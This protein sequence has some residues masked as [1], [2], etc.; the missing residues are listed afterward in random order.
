METRVIKDYFG[1]YAKKVPISAIKSMTGECL[2][3]SGAMQSV[4]SIMAINNGVIPPTINYQEVDDE[5]DLDYVPNKSRKLEVR[6]AL[7]DDFSD[8]GNISSL[9]ISKYS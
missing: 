3:A 2:D 7:I 5:C 8:T 1:G 9:I 4:A 6:N